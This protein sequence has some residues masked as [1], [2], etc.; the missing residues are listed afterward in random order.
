M[1]ETPPPRQPTIT[2]MISLE[3]PTQVRV[4][5]DAGRVA[6]LVRSTNWKENRYEHHCFVYDLSQGRAFQLTRAGD[7]TQVEWIDAE[8]LAVLKSEGGEKAQIWLFEHLI[9]EGVQL[10][11]H[12]GGVQSFKPFAAGVLFLANDPER[13]EKKPRSEEFG[14]VTHF[15]QEDSAAGLYYASFERTRAYHWALRQGTAE[16]AKALVRPVLELSKVLDTPLKITAF[17]P[18]PQNDAVY[19]NCRRRDDLVYWEETSCFRLAL[20]PEQSLET[21]I[22]RQEGK[23]RDTPAEEEKDLSYL[24]TLTQLALPKGAEICGTS[25]DGTSLLVR[26][27]ERDNLFLTQADLWTLD[28]S[29]NEGLLEDAG[30]ADRLNKITAALDREILDQHWGNDGIFVSYAAGTKTELARLT[31]SGAMEALRLDGIAPL[32]E[33]HISDGGGLGFVGASEATY[34]EVFLAAPRAV[35]G[36]RELTQLTAFGEQVTGWDLG[37]VET[38]RWTSRDGTEIEGVLRKPPGFNPTKRYPLVF[39]VHGGP[40]WFSSAYLLDGG[41]IAYYPAVQFAQRDMLVLKPNYRGSIGRGQAFLELNKDNLGIGDLQDL[42]SAIDHLDAQGFVDTD[43]VGCMGWSQGGYISAF[44]TT[45]SDRF[46]AVSVGAGVS[47]WYTYHITN[48]IP[49]FTIHYLSGNPFRDRE[50]YV[51]TAPMSALQSAR[52]PTLIQHGGRDQRVPLANATELY[53]GLQEMGVPVELFVFPEMAHPIT[54][55]RENRAVMWQNLTWFCH[56][57]LGDELDFFRTEG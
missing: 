27:R 39:V 45:H 51:K 15:E 48:D 55:P 32:Y 31:P 17:Y 6:Y 30:L 40:T 18:A 11:A 53:R 24:G 16:E 50:L 8:S 46:R 21:Y 23:E 35:S 52:T 9:G 44:A 49:H 13:E 20:D 36:A 4:A 5:P 26:H 1:P 2:Q 41:D 54:K 38:I 33:F 29:Q 12:E 3:V 47:D 10:T 7:A 22:A 19:F 37:S 28:L 56:Y 42:E 14:T 34:P 25:P 43:R 57:L